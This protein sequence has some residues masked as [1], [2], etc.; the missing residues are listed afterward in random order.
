MMRLVIAGNRYT[1]PGHSFVRNLED[2]HGLIKHLLIQRAILDG[3][4][5][6]LD[7]VIPA[8]RH[9]QIKSC[10]DGLDT[11]PYA[12][13]VGYDD[14]I[15][16]PV[17]PQHVSQQPLVATAV[18]AVESVVG[19]HQRPRTPLFDSNLEIRQIDFAQR[20]LVDARPR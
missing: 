12:R 19:A 1:P 8:I 15:E 18:F 4:D 11:V 16:A 14:A 9:L 17:V 5:H 7:V 2:A 3:F 10:F 6:S 20:A 13:P